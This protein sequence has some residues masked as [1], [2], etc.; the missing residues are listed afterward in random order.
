MIFIKFIDKKRTVLLEKS[1]NNLN[2]PEIE[3]WLGG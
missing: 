2:P 1:R 3:A